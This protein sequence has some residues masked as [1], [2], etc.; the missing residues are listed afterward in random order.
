MSLIKSPPAGATLA[1]FRSRFEAFVQSDEFPCVG[2]RSAIARGRGR[3]GLY[4]R[5]G[6]TCSAAAL[7]RDLEAFS[8]EFPNPGEVPATFVA[9]F[10]DTVPDETEFE[11]LM[12]RQLQEID[13]HD[14]AEY[15]WCP[16]VS[17]DPS[18]P[19]FSFSAAGRAFFVVGLSPVA[20]RLARRAPMPCLVFNFHDQF[21][22][23]RAS[24]KYD[25]FTRVIRARDLVLQGAVNPAL[26]PF[27]EQSEARQYSG[28]AAEPGWRCPFSAGVRDAS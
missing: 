22:H 9:M 1:R 8:A 26:A 10:E 12:W 5:L 19:N 2:A 14:R 17:S 16:S 4:G 18:D 23:L 28:R 25:N 11:Q 20:S 24:G 6:H 15:G 7:W 3:F 27:G 21:E 13:A